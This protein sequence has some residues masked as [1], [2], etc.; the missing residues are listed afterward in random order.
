MNRLKPYRPQPAQ[1]PADSLRGDP[2]DTRDPR[3]FMNPLTGIRN[4]GKKY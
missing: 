3:R 2:C 4:T 1:I